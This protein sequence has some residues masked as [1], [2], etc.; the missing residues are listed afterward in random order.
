MQGTAVPVTVDKM[1]P[2]PPRVMRTYCLRVSAPSLVST[3]APKACESVD[4]GDRASCRPAHGP[5]RA[6]TE[7][8]E[9]RWLGRGRSS[10][11]PNQLRSL[12]HSCYSPRTAATS[13]GGK[14]GRRPKNGF[15]RLTYG[16]AFGTR[17]A[18]LSVSV[19]ACIAHCATLKSLK[20]GTECRHSATRKP[21][22]A[23][24]RCSLEPC[25]QA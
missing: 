21:R 15:P 14:R 2:D 3:V 8:S 7:Q 24:H 17:P 10:R 6:A 11:P 18:C 4:S 13:D 1:R 22:A 20:F 16:D 12:R 19:G 9:P 25:W 23:G 5:S